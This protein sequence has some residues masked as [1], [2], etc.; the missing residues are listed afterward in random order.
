MSNDIHCRFLYAGDR[1]RTRRSQT[2]VTA[3]GKVA[4]AGKS[5]VFSISVKS[6]PMTALRCEDDCPNYCCQLGCCA[7]P[8]SQTD[9]FPDSFTQ[10]RESDTAHRQT[11]KGLLNSPLVCLCACRSRTARQFT[12]TSG[13]LSARRKPGSS[14]RSPLSWS[15]GQINFVGE[16]PRMRR[17]NSFR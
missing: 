12:Q 17:R 10:I 16:L 6:C 8:A 14:D 4:H 1:L 2:N 7:S 11:D 13:C 15:S 5:V 3:R 9:R